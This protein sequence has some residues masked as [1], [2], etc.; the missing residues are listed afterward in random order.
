MI[1]M[2]I[3]GV[4][5]ALGW[6][7]SPNFALSVGS[8]RSRVTIGETKGILELVP[9]NDGELNSFTCRLWLT[10]GPA[11]PLVLSRF[12][13]DSILGDRTLAKIQ[14]GRGRLFRLLN[15]TSVYGVTWVAIGFIGQAIFTG[16]MFLQWIV[17][18]RRQESVVTESFW[19]FS[20][21]GGIVL[22]VYFIWRQDVVPLVGQASGIVIYIRNITIMRRA[23]GGT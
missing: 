15:V 9:S 20:L 11:E 17:S 19:W 14:Q 10:D 23:A 5:I 18:E 16:R 4:W 21:I 22:F 3:L 2:S 6:S 1:V 7:S 12:Q 8:I 13:A